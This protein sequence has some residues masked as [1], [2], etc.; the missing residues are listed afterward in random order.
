MRLFP[1]ISGSRSTWGVLAG[2]CGIVCNLLLFAFKMVTGLASGSI[3]VVAD[4][5]NNL[6]DSAS[7]IVTVIG[8]RWSRKPADR[9]HP[10]GHERIE[11]M[12]GVFVA[13]GI[14]LVGAGLLQE[15]VRRLLNPVDVRYTAAAAAALV[16]TVA[17]KVALRFFY[18]AAAR[19]IE[20][21]ALF[22]TARDSGNDAVAALAV[23]LGVAVR[24]LTGVSL[25]GWLGCAV[26]LFIIV[27][28]VLAVRDTISPLLGEAPPKELVDSLCAAIAEA[29]GVRGMHDLIVHSYGPNRYFATVHAEMDA[30]V[31]PLVSHETIDNLERSVEE[32][33]GIKL[34]VHYDPL[35][36]PSEES[37]KISQLIAHILAGIDERLS[38]HDL[39]LV[40]AASFT[41]VIFDIGVP[42]E[43]PDSSE[44]LCARVS[45]GLV[46]QRA[47]L[48][49]V[50]Q[51]DRNYTELPAIGRT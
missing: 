34:V 30:R 43:Y 2:T 36:P 24:A 49:P 6:S 21:P 7:S 32:R 27:S 13:V 38:M 31:S 22:V 46:G 40:K 16:V 47:D 1:T 11:Y 14:I 25:D 26:A 33:L 51:I 35:D 12:T 29:D 44:L 8:F 42:P 19:K 41:N 23:L 50:I 15:S 45:S 3:A 20:S 18:R 10:F 17:V 4:A 39:R 48:R 9:E 37:A 28:G 5:V